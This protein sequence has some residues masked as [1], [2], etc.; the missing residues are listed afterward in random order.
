MTDLLN[1]FREALGPET[2]SET[3]VP[4][5]FHKIV[6]RYSESRR[7]YHNLDHLNR[8]FILCDQMKIE[9]PDII[10]AI[11]YHD[12][13]YNPI[14][15]DNERKSAAFAGKSLERVGFNRERTERIGEMILAT[16]DHLE[17]EYDRATE[18]L[19]DLD[20]SILGAEIDE[21]EMY[22]DGVRREYSW[23]PDD[24]FR[25]NRGKFLHGIF[26]AE[27]IFRTEKFRKRFEKKARENVSRE[28]ASL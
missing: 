21:Y 9:D 13:I 14:L 2:A 4:E 24:R 8:I 19:L 3:I 17:G 15:G 26:E 23:V 18:L 1:R 28:L 27:H 22:S 25:R 5:E 6:Q 7:Y 11:F 16:R 10:L 20:I 12:I